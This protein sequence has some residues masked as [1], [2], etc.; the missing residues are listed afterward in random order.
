MILRFEKRMEKNM[1]NKIAKIETLLN[2]RDM[3]L[4]VI[5]YFFF[6]LTEMK[7][8]GTLEEK[9]LRKWIDVFVYTKY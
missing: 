6:A 5:C 1:N 9:N 7:I 4:I 2:L 3:L 8:I